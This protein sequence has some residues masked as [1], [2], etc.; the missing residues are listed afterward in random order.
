VS[1]GTNYAF[2]DGHV[3]WLKPLATMAPKNLLTTNPDD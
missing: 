1:Y 3:K 2:C